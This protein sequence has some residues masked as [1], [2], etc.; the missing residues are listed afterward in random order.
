MTGW[1]GVDDGVGGGSG[2]L[3]GLLVGE[4]GGVGIIADLGL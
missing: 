4:S 1:E 2:G 3:L